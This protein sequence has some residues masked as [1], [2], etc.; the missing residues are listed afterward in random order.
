VGK[1]GKRLWLNATYNPVIDSSGKT[2]KIIKFVT[3]QTA[4]KRVQSE[5]EEARQRAEHA[6]AVKGSF[7]ANMSHE[8]RT[9]MNAI[10]GFSD[11]LSQSVKDPTDLKYVNTIKTASR[12]LL[13][14][15]NDI[16]DT[17]KLER[18]AI[19][20][21][22]LNFSLRDLCAHVVDLEHILAFK[23]GIGLELVYPAGT[24]EQFR[25]DPFRIQQVLLNLLGNAIKFTDKGAVT[26]QVSYTAGWVHIA[27]KDTGIGIEP[28]RL[29]SIFDSFTQ[30]DVTMTRKYGGTGLGTTI[31]RQLVELMGGRIEVTSTLGRGSVFTVFLPLQPAEQGAPS[32]A[33]AGPAGSA[34]MPS[35][36]AVPATPLQ[37]LVVDDVEANLDLA[38]IL[39][40]REGHTV[41]R[42]ADGV[43]ALAAFGAGRF[44][45][46]LMDLQMPGI[47]G[48]EA[49]AAIRDVER[50]AQR[51]RTPIIALSAN[52]MHAEKQRAFDAGMDGYVGKPIDLRQLRNEIARVLH[53]QD[54]RGTQEVDLLDKAARYVDIDHVEG[55]SVWG[56]RGVYDQQL[57]RFVQEVKASRKA[58]NDALQ[59]RDMAAL[60]FLAHR[61]RGASGNLCL[62][63]LHSVTGEVES[64]I[65][66]LGR[67]GSKQAGIALF[68]AMDSLEKAYE[69]YMHTAPQ[70]AAAPVEPAPADP[71]RVAALVD[72]LLPLLAAGRLDDVL[73]DQLYGVL[74]ATV[75]RA[76]GTDINAFKFIKACKPWRSTKP[77]W[78]RGHDG[79]NQAQ[80]LVGGR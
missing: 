17:A 13:T 15:I 33:A 68:S 31:A 11:L 34:A 72:Q 38:E 40:K 23:K 26:I 30:A 5:L 47:N 54:S 77:V 79:V 41:A 9:P 78:A 35:V 6:A 48:L 29:A 7:L 56:D 1:G 21:E 59:Q 27:V 32:A 12:S 69:A 80:T 22:E 37:V 70:A 63:R 10:I 55:V 28:G 65:D 19:E 39:L 62:R 3:D 73:L 51:A 43:Q 25:G 2:V 58:L 46:I 50:D 53:A 71:A 36:V 44:D 42:A 18:G 57:T 45:V 61:M 8:I 16:L 67:D 4:M 76:C 74:P 52:V 24:R 20:L 60:K 75:A 14:L 49:T 64:S 66:A